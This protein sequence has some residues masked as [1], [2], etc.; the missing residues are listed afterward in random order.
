MI[1]NLLMPL[2][3]SYL[4]G[5]TILVVAATSKGKKGTG[6]DHGPAW[7]KDFNWKWLAPTSNEMRR[8]AGVASRRGWPERQVYDSCTAAYTSLLEC[9]MRKI[10]R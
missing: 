5:W 7:C 2:V 8:L 10:R 1:E 4:F 9:G 6:T 3:T